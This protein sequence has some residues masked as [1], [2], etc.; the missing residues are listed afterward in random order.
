MALSFGVW[1]QTYNHDETVMQQFAAQE[2]G[3]GSLTPA[4]AYK[5]RYGSGYYNSANSTN[6]LLY[7]THMAIKL[8]S[9]VPF[10]DKID[11]S[12][13][14]RADVEAVNLDDRMTDILWEAEKKKINTKLEVLKANIEKITLS[15]G[16]AHDYDNWLDIYN[17]IVCGI[18]AMQR[19][20]LPNSERQRQYVAIYRDIR[21]KNMEL[22]SELLR[23]QTAKNMKSDQ[24]NAKTPSK[25]NIHNIALEAKGRWK[26]AWTGGLTPTG[27]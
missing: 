4:V 16:T 13:V 23:W 24:G 27:H 11:S 1:S 15:G 17:C 5:L 12:M 26:I 2:T 20:Y 9:E 14:E 25:T 21:S 3:V 7:R 8:S 10:A 6:K 19:G 18:T 22:V